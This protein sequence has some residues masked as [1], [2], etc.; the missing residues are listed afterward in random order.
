M[1]VYSI[2][3]DAETGQPL[4]GGSAFSKG[5][6]SWEQRSV[7]ERGGTDPATGKPEWLDT[8]VLRTSPRGVPMWRARVE[9][10]SHLGRLAELDLWIESEEEPPATF[11]E[12]PG[13]MAL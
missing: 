7:Y 6:L 13:V 11:E 1:A 2:V 4:L 5:R 8:G 9:V 3:L 10:V 12:F